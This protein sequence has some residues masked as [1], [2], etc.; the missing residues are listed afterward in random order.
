MVDKNFIYRGE[1]K[2]RAHSVIV[3]GGWWNEWL[4][5]IVADGSSKK[6]KGKMNMESDQTNYLITNQHNVY[7]LSR[8]C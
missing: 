6:G 4:H 1:Q 8:D 7:L 3:E 2:I 5:Y